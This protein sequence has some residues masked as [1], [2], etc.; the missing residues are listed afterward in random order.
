MLNTFLHGTDYI[1][2][3][4]LTKF[5]CTMDRRWFTEDVFIKKKYKGVRFNGISTQNKIFSDFCKKVFRERTKIYINGGILKHVSGFNYLECEVFC[6]VDC[7]VE[8][9]SKN[10]NIYCSSIEL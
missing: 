4:A 6:T 2:V 9:R 3:Y 7:D 1:K 5:F 10:V 8:K